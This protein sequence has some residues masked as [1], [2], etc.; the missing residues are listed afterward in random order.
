LRTFAPALKQGRGFGV[1]TKKIAIMKATNWNKSKCNNVRH[2]LSSIVSPQFNPHKIEDNVLSM[3]FFDKLYQ[4]SINMSQNEAEY[5][6]K[7]IQEAI[8][9]L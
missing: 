1:Q 9:R 3:T 7:Q 8:D 2:G 6:I 5:L 4:M